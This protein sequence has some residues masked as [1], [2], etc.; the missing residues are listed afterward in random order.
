VDGHGRFWNAGLEQL[1]ELL[2]KHRTAE[3]VALRLVTLAGLQKFQFFVCFQ[4]L[5]NDTQIQ[6]LAHANH[7][8]HDGGVVGSRGDVARAEVIDGDLSSE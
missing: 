3:T 8:G 4:A 5:G 2:W 7:R 1:G 6:A